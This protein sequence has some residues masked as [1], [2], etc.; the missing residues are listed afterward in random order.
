VPDCVLPDGLV[1]ISSRIFLALSIAWHRLIQLGCHL[2]SCRCSY[3]TQDFPH[4]SSCTSLKRRRETVLRTTWFQGE[5]NRRK[6]L[7]EDH[8]EWRLGI[9]TR[10][11]TSRGRAELIDISSMSP[12]DRDTWYV[13]FMSITIFP[14]T[15]G[16][17]RTFTAYIGYKV[18][19][20]VS[21]IPKID[22][23]MDYNE[24]TISAST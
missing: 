8:T 22:N 20:W 4:L 17:E 18:K 2:A 15:L 3:K 24:T 19:A 21:N 6:L 12:V 1:L 23:Q 14:R 16:T 11:R 7:Q 10:H 5:W 9:G 13:D